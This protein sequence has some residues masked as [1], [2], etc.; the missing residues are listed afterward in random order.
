MLKK[1]F[2]SAKNHKSLS[3]L[4]IASLLVM[5]GCKSGL[6]GTTDIPTTTAQTQPAVPPAPIVVDGVRASYNDVVE[7]TSPAVVRIDAERKAKSNLPQ[8]PFF[9]DPQFREFFRGMPQQ[10]QP[11]RPP[12]ERGLG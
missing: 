12:T 8:H 6:V 2:Q 11:Q 7:K 5:T 3:F 10:Q 4:L 1:M 9:N